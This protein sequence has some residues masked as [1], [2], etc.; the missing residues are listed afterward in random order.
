MHQFDSFKRAD[1]YALG[2]VLWE[3]CR[4]C[5]LVADEYQLPYFDLVAP[6]PSVEEMKQVVCDKKMRPPI[7]EAWHTACPVRN[8]YYYYAD[9]CNYG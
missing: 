2:L 1:M 3:L 9:P 8:Y 6:D 5:S 4:R 7:P